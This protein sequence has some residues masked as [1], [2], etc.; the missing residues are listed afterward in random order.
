MSLH[1]IN[2]LEI[3]AVLAGIPTDK[4][5]H[6][7][8]EAL[9][10]N[11]QLNEFVKQ[12]GIRYQ[13][14]IPNGS[15]IEAGF[16]QLGKDI[17]TDLDWDVNDIAV[18]AVVT[19]TFQQQIPALANRLHE[20][21]ELSTSCAAFDINSGCSGFAYGLAT[22]GALLQTQ[23]PQQPAKALLFIGDYSNEL[24]G[25]HDQATK[26]LFSDVLAVIALEIQK[27]KIQPAFFK[28]ES[29]G[30]GKDAIYTERVN[31]EYIMRLNGL[32]VYQYSMTHVPR[33]L[34]TFLSTFHLKPK[35]IVLH[36]ANLLINRSIEKQVNMQDSIFL[37]SLGEFGN[38]G[39]ASIP[40]TMV[41]HQHL[42]RGQDVLICGFGVGFSV[43][44]AFINVSEQCILQIK[45]ITDV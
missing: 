31:G 13:F 23:L 28:L 3:C 18:C 11:P 12:T 19:Q 29:D 24:I 25:E 14:K 1:S 26:Y 21:M 2:G 8:S 40:L 15:L 4:N 33:H 22:I 36:Q 45:M 27:D 42:L 30:K 41:L 5:D 7:S 17:L 38:A 44:S 20:H 6:L 16:V 10:T 34:T 32:D 37:N 43:A 35:Y 39:S 9:F